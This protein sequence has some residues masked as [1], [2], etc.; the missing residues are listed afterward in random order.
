MIRANSAEVGCAYY[1]LPALFL[2]FSA[3]L[4]PLNGSDTKTLRK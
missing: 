1:E 2:F 3:D 4:I